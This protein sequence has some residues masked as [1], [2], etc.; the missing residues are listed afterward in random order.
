MRAGP[1]R[2]EGKGTILVTG[3]AG[4]IGSHTCKALAVAGY[5]PAV[6][7]N[8]STGNRWAVRW[9]PFEHGDILDTGRLHEIFLRYR[10]VGLIHF[11]A[12]A[13]VGESMRS[14]SIYYHTNVTGSINLL[15]ACRLNQVPAVV[16]SSTCAIYGAPTSMPIREETPAFPIN[17]YG[18]SK[19]MVERVLDDYNAAYGLQ[20]MAL[21]YFNA[22]GADPDGD[23]GER[24]DVE[25]HLVPLAIDAVLGRRPPLM[26]FGTDHPT[27]DGTAIRDYVH[28]CDLADAHVRALE[29]LL[30][31][32][33]SRKLNLGTGRGYSVLE[34]LRTIADVSGKSVPHSLAPKRMG[35]PPE[36]VADSAAA[37]ATLGNDLAARSSLERI[38]ETAW[39]WHRGGSLPALSS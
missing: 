34:V 16:F 25:T 26:V 18:A 37:R 33:A 8:L 35:D 3:G 27:P 2:G 10:P 22:A 5:R 28:V 21:R 39:A 1:D 11:A 9:G 7:D 6:Y 20:Y 12:T 31:G 30:S 32:D 29:R 19:L 14:P 15:E 17:P 13:L 4:Y 38:V 24:R 36:L 23:L